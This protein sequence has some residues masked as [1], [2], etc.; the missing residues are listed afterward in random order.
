VHILAGEENH[1]SV[2]SRDVSFVGKGRELSN[3]IASE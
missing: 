2:H 1:N 3:A